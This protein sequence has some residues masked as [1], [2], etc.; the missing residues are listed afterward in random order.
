MLATLLS[1]IY[2]YKL[3][4]LLI[5]NKNLTLTVVQKIRPKI[6]FINFSLCIKL[7]L[8]DVYK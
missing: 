4:M 5:L 3:Y 1:H 8:V 7:Y 6:E 2:V